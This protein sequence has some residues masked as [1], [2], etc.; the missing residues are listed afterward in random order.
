MKKKSDK[1]IED[2]FLFMN[3]SIYVLMSKKINYE[4]GVRDI[5]VYLFSDIH[6]KNNHI[7]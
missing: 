7:E 5:F 6:F 2:K 3:N 1:N 4:N